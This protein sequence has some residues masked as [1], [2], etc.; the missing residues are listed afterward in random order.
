MALEE[1][2][3]YRFKLAPL[4]YI[5]LSNRDNTIFTFFETLYIQPVII[6]VL[7]MFELTKPMKYLRQQAGL[8]SWFD[9][10]HAIEPQLMNCQKN[11]EKKDLI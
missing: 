4:F 1:A 10:V 6:L 9:T 5:F 11:R 7:V 8:L 3:N 2:V